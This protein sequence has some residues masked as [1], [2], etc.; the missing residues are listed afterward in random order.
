MLFSVK[1]HGG[2][3]VHLKTN[4]RFILEYFFI[5]TCASKPKQTFCLIKRNGF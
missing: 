3:Y 5:T 4:L 2:S 1:G